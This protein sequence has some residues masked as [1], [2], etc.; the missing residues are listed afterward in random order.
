[1]RTASDVARSRPPDPRPYTRQ[2][3]QPPHSS[4]VQKVLV[5]PGYGFSFSMSTRSIDV[6]KAGHAPPIA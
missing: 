5:R 3:I 2:E 4:K 6:P 1:M